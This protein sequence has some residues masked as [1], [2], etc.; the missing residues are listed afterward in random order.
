MMTSNCEDWGEHVGPCHQRSGNMMG[1][2]TKSGFRSRKGPK[3]AA[4]LN[5]GV[6]GFRGGSGRREERGHGWWSSGSG[7]GWIVGEVW[8]PEIER[9]EAADVTRGERF[10]R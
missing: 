10:T 7:S 9:R 4:T 3:L 8:M 1:P 5:S 6:V 2:G